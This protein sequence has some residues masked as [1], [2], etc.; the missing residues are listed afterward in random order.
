M[1]ALNEELDSD[2]TI[3][4]ESRRAR[5]HYGTSVYAPFVEGVH[6]SS[7]KYVPPFTIP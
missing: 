5:R 2:A 7:R 1:K 4:V 3:R 6:D